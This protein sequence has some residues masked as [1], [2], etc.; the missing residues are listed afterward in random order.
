MEITFPDSDRTGR[1]AS[2]DNRPTVNL[3]ND[4]EVSS[5]HVLDSGREETDRDES[6]RLTRKDIDEITRHS[7]LH[8]IMSWLRELSE[9]RQSEV[10][11]ALVVAKRNMKRGRNK[12][13][14][15]D[16]DER[17]QVRKS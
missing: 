6:Y 3:I 16:G 2:S 7:D 17:R 1:S 15:K 9:G 8:Q 13:H 4:A 12:E 11:A 10:T 5:S 14:V